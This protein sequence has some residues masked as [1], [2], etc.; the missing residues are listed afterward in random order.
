MSNYKAV[1]AK[2]DFNELEKEIINYWKEKNIFKKSIENRKNCPEFVFFEGPPTANGRPGV[3]HVLVRTFK[4]LVC[5]YQTMNG[6]KVER[7]AGWDEHGLPVEIEVQKTQNLKSKEDILKLGIAKF[8]ELCAAS[9]QKYIN[10]WEELT[11]RMAYWVDFKNAYRTSDAKYIEKIW[12][13]L[14]KFHDNDL[15]YKGYKVVPWACDSETTVSQAEVALGYKDVI[16]E[17]AYVK[18]KLNVENQEMYLLAWTTTPW[19]LPSNVALAVSEHINYVVAK[20]KNSNEILIISEKRYEKVLNPEEYEKLY[21]K[22]GQEL[23]FKEG[24]NLKYYNLFFGTEQPII[25]GKISEDNY[26]IEDCEDSGTGVV[27]IAPHFGEDDFKTCQFN[28]LEINEKCLVSPQ[29]IFTEDAPD[30]LKNQSLFNENKKTKE[31]EFIRINKVIN[32][33]LERLGNLLKTEKYEHSYP[34][35]WRTGNPL[36]YYLR[37]SWYVKTQSLRDSLIQANS[38]VQWYPEHVKEGRFGKWLENNVDWSISRERFWGTPLPIWIG[39]KTGKVQVI[40]SIKELE[41]KSNKKIIDPH[42]HIIDEISWEEDGETFKRVGEVLDCWFDSGSMPCAS[43]NIEPENFKVA[44]YICEAVDQTRG[45]FYSLL[46]VAVASSYNKKETTF[47]APYKKVLCLGHILDKDGQKMSKSKGNV[48]NPWELFEKFGADAVR[49]YLVSTYS[50]GNPIK[51]DVSGILEITKRFFLQLWNTY[52]FFVLY[53]NLD[54]ITTEILE[55]YK[56]NKNIKAIDK[57]ILTKLDYLIETV[58]KELEAFEFSKASLAIEKFTDELSN[59]WVRANRERFWNTSSDNIDYDAYYVLN[60]C[61]K[62]L[63]SICSP[64]IP[65]LSEVIYL[66]LKYKQEPESIHL[67]DRLKRKDYEFLIERDSLCQAM[68]KALEIINTARNQRQKLG[69]KIRQPL[70]A[71]Q[72]PNKYEDLSAFHDLIK[73]ELNIKE[74][75][76][77]GEEILLDTLINDE[78]L[79]EGLSRELIHAIQ[80]LR[81]ESNFNVADRIKL[82][83]FMPI[84]KTSELI[85]SQIEHIKKETLSLD[86]IETSNINTEFKKKIKLEGETIEIGVEKV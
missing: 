54:K 82:Y 27:H 83:L 68:E 19:T 15:L 4:D 55:N 52:S 32:N 47:K 18:F 57:W 14:K 44:D 26:F 75:I 30:F 28:S 36:I 34:H 12:S 8:N 37:P 69:I 62:T 80:G 31:L 13:I 1:S 40:A 56:P 64:I 72:I 21:I 7:N 42:K 53:A 85:R 60:E 46:A 76:Y 10:E 6:K 9:T 58:E 78:L 81:K 65:M 77:K 59:I 24:S 5:R 25:K 3:H 43:F 11:E 79:A 39:E 22:T 51:F 41:K 61:L 63:V 71:V 84:N 17:T 48:V 50:A 38:Q 49:W 74:V 67:T 2:A 45:W 70:K 35:N 33:E 23:F 20:N 86:L 73:K 66:N 16:D 29:G